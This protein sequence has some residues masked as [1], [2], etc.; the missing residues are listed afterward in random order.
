M[1]PRSRPDAPSYPRAF[2][3]T[4][5][6]FLIFSGIYLMVSLTASILRETGQFLMKDV[7]IGKVF[8]GNDRP[9]HGDR[10]PPA[11]LEKPWTM[12]G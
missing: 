8:A 4:L 5:L 6:A 9:A 11:K 3:D 1:S 10:R 2:E 12:P 7:R